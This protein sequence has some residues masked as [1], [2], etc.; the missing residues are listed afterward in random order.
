MTHVYMKFYDNCQVVHKLR[1]DTHM[2]TDTHTHTHTHNTYTQHDIISVISFLNKGH[3][4][5]TFGSNT[6]E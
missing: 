5:K 6:L 4:T 3:R 1:A 2:D